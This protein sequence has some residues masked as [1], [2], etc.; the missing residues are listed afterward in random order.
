MTSGGNDEVLWLG[1]ARAPGAAGARAVRVRTRGAAPGPD[2]VAEEID[3]PFA[4]DD[5]DPW[6]RAAEARAGGL[7]A[8]IAALELL[9]PLRPSKVIC[10]GRNFRAH[11][12][13]LGNEVPT[14]P[15]LFFKPPSC[16]VPSGQAVQLPRGY[17]RID[18]ESELVV[19]VGRKASH[20]AAERAFEHVAGYAVGNDVS[21][22]DLQKRDK[23]WTRAKGFDGFGPLAAWIRLTPPGFVPPAEARICGWLNGQA[24]Q[25][26]PL[27]DMV[28]DMPYLFAYISACM[29]LMP[30]DLIFTGTPEGVAA[31]QPGDSAKVALDG[32]ELAPLVTPF[33]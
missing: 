26:A 18:M 8:P 12:A 14:E 20:V 28:F 17:E 23:Q 4:D 31:L 24:K 11:A 22:R 6:Q 29:T 5:G 19:V 30:G 15:L 33:T 9:A 16:L 2:D 1:R 3:D 7:R 32:F 27:A 21:N 13:E 10:V 25:S